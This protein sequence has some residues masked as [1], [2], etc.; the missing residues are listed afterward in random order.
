[1]GRVRRLALTMALSLV[2]SG[3]G[4]ILPDLQG[5]KPA[6]AANVVAQLR[7]DGAIA[8][9]G[10]GGSPDD[11]A[12]GSE[13][14]TPEEALAAFA[15]GDAPWYAFMPLAGCVQWRRA[16]HWVLYAHVVDER[17]RAVALFTNQGDPDRPP[18]EWQLWQVAACDA[19]EFD[20]AVPTGWG[21]TVW[22]N[23]EGRVPT[24][25]IREMDECGAARR[26]EVEGRLF[27]RAPGEGAPH[28]LLLD[29]YA[30]AVSLPGDA[31]ATPYRHGERRLW[32]AADER[33][34]YVGIPPLLER[35]PRVRGDEI[36]RVDCN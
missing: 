1:M 17:P 24:T 30:E 16:A 33:A 7:C 36:V 15:I 34:A 13:G 6:W 2:A 22:S 21:L 28:E 11:V 12:G 23:A 20:P 19:A 5:A 26:L 18:G 3:C 31:E 14:A 10:A 32:F 4:N 35:W 27:L 8:P 9:I 25:V 29:E